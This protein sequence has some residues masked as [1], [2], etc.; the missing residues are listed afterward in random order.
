VVSG[1]LVAGFSG[2]Q[3]WRAGSQGGSTKTL[4]A[5]PLITLQGVTRYPSFSPDGNQVAFTWTGPTRDNPDI[6][7]QQIGSGPPFRLTTDPRNDYNPVWAPN[8]RWIAFLRRQ[9]ETD[10]SELRLIPPLGGPER[11]LREIRVQDATPP[12]LA[13]CPDSSCLVV[14][15]SAGEG[16]PAALFLLWLDTGEKTQLTHPQPPGWGDT[17][18]A[19]SPDGS[20]VVF[21]R[22]INLQNGEYGKSSE[23]QE[24]RGYLI[25]ILA[26]L[27]PT[28]PA[29]ALP[30]QR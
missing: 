20:W 14:T 19:I 23:Q 28:E 21:R 22:Q 29:C 30:A 1:L 5:V 24:T 27:E 17:N 9:W 26:C 13:W 7:V 18:P 16:M 6:Y 3:A 25:T 11:K 15:D 10:T 8:G 12:Y 4:R 2:W